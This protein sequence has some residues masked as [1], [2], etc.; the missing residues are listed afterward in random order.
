[1]QDPTDVYDLDLTMDETD[2]RRRATRALPVRCY[3]CAAGC[4][5]FEFANLMLT[6]TRQQ[7]LVVSAAIAATRSQLLA[8]QE[9]LAPA[10]D[11]VVM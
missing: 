4:V 6:F 5:H 8:E 7:F 9:T 1:M 10:I 3:K 11:S 2:E